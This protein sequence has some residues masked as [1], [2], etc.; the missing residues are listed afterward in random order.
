MGRVGGEGDDVTAEKEDALD[1]DYLTLN[2]DEL[3]ILEGLKELKDDGDIRSVTVI[4]NSA[5]PISTGFLFEEDY[6][7]DA[8]LWVGSVGQTGLYA[9]GD[10][11]S[12]T[13]NP[14]GSLPD[15]WWMDNQ[16]NPVMNN[17]GSYLYDGVNSYNFSAL[18]AYGK[19]V[20]YQEGIYLGYKYT[21]TRYEDVVMGT[22]NVGKYYYNSVV[23][24]PFGYGLSYSS[25]DFSDVSVTREGD[26]KDASYSLTVTVTNT[27]S[28]AGKKTVQ[29][30]AQ[31]PYTDYDRQN[32]I[33]KA[34]VELVGY[35]KTQ[36]LQPGESETLTIAVPEYFLTSYDTFGTGA[37]ILE[38]GTYY[39]TAAENSHEAANNILA[40]KGYTTED[41]MTSEGNTD[42]VY[43]FD[44]SFDAETYATSYGTGAE[45]TPLFASADMNRYEGKGDNAIVYYSRSDWEGTVTPGFVKLT[46]TDMLAADVMLDD[47]DLPDATG[48]EFPKMG[49]EADKARKAEKPTDDEK[50]AIEKWN[51]FVKN[52]NRPMKEGLYGD[53]ANRD[54]IAE[55]IRF[56]ST[57]A[58]GTGD[59]KW[60]SFADYVQRMK[61]DQKAI[62]YITGGDEENLRKSPLLEAYTKKGFE[63]LILDGDIDEIVIPGYG[64]YK[65]FELKAV[66]RAGS[67]EE[68][69]VDK[70]EA[71]KK[72]KDFKP[73][74]EKLKKA[75]GDR[76]KDV[77]LSNRLT[78]SPCC[79]VIDE[80]DP[81]LQMERMM[82]A[83]GQGMPSMVKPILEVNAD[84]AIL[85]KVKATDDES[86]IG[87]IATVLL[88][89][90]LLL[91]GAEIKDPAD[92]VKKLNKLIAAQ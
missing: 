6:G 8:A 80:N 28:A 35:N 79:I 67:D 33:E 82:K 25:F 16:L 77:K 54:E 62:Y 50:K 64:K 29:V 27:G 74:V 21:E 92:F 78:D 56:K 68:L 83:M 31:K 10:V 39:L 3:S 48:V 59:D 24:F 30:Y 53:Y 65:D 63:V 20:V 61:P 19:Y 13:V 47:A 1:G 42:L 36:I 5:N 46:M 85:Q 75:L 22:P 12:G 15:T 91:G 55:I 76:V 23:S 9:V 34:S 49:E 41:G 57:D 84:H 14:S 51:K 17:F 66:N 52:Y 18:S 90:A 38:D 4:I 72:E 32:Q 37:Y 58:S 69:G 60:T 81:S 43:S 73:V 26:G 86:L 70:A 89:Q 45:V 87:D 7:V 11:I 2:E 40:A 88:D 44:Q 71:E